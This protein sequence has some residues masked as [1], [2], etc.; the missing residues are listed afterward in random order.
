MLYLDSS[1]PA[2]FLLFVS[3]SLI[4]GAWF[5]RHNYGFLDIALAGLPLAALCNVILISWLPAMLLPVLVRAQVHRSYIGGLMLLQVRRR[6]GLS[7]P[8]NPSQHLCSLRP[9]AGII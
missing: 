9:H 7:V 5:V 3:G 4:T 8:C 1:N 6:K 2:E